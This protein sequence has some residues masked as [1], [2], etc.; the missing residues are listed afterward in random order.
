MYIFCVFIK[1]VH[2]I[3]FSI[4]LAFCQQYIL[5]FPWVITYRYNSFFQSYIFVH[6]SYIYYD[7]LQMFAIDTQVTKTD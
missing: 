2:A 1:E 5:F 3:C 7:C 4:K 6:S